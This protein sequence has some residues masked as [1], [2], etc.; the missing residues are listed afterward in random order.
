MDLDLS[1]PFVLSRAAIPSMIDQGGGRIV[2]V[3]SMAGLAAFA[4]RGAYSAAKAGLIML[5]RVIA[6]EYGSRGIR[7]NAVAPGV[8]ETPMTVAFLRAEES[9][10]SIRAHA[11]AG[12]ACG[13]DEIAAPVVFLAGPGSGYVN[14]TV[15]PVDGGWTSGYA[16]ARLSPQSADTTSG[17]DR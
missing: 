13:P 11:P 1:A 16:G 7:A 17:S 4:D 12:R 3:A 9:A 2:N 8:V 5:T 10:A 14:G 15:L 6:V